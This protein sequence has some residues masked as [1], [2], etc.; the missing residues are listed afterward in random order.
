MTD[1][2]VFFFLKWMENWKKQLQKKENKK[3]RK[4]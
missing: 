2:D 4:D 3:E 1:E